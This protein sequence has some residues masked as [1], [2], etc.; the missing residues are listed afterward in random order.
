[1]EALCQTCLKDRA[2]FAAA[3]I[4][5]SAKRL[6]SVQGGRTSRSPA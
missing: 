1:V 3:Q 5:W 4:G 2:A 6:R